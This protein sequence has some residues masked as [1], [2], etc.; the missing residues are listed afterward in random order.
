MSSID[1]AASNGSNPLL[2]SWNTPFRAPPFEQIRPR[3]FPA[4]VRRGT[5]RRI[6]RKSTRSRLIPQPPTFANTIDAL[7]QSGELM[8]QVGGV[9]WNL[10]GSNTN[11]EIQAIERVIS[12]VSAKHYSDIGMNGALF[13][14]IDAL[15]S[16]VGTLGL[17]DE[18]KRVLELT[19]KRFVRSGAQLDPAA[20]AR[21]VGDRRAA[22]DSWHAVQPERAG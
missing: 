22:R 2:G 15:W 3:A 6:G 8:S 17:S 11:P 7:E 9:F 18:Q 21:L 16:K 1:D 19:H 14:R 13:A 20:K 12:P 4:G 5:S 10:S